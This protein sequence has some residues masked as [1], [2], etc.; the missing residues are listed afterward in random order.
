[1]AVKFVAWIFATD[2]QAFF[3]HFMVPISGAGSDMAGKVANIPM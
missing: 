1:M 2:I 3:C